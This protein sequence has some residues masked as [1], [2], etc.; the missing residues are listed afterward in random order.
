MSQKVVR[1][2]ET[3]S[4]VPRTALFAAQRPVQYQSPDGDHLSEE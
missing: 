4:P 3:R 1:V 2:P